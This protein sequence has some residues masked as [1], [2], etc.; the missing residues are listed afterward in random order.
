MGN[1]PAT[2]LKNNEYNISRQRKFLS[3][4]LSEGVPVILFFYSFH[5]IY[6]T[7]I[8]YMGFN[9]LYTIIVFKILSV[10]CIFGAVTHPITVGTPVA[11]GSTA[12]SLHVISIMRAL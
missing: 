3:T 5:Y 9:R 4:P 7:R 6:C 8:D 10:T 2:H 11:C 12:Y 1:C